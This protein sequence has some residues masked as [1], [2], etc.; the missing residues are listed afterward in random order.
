[1]RQYS[2]HAHAASLTA[3]LAVSVRRSAVWCIES[4]RTVEHDGDSNESL[5][6]WPRLLVMESRKDLSKLSWRKK[7]ED[8]EEESHECRHNEV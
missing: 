6:F 1:M 8:R 2:T 3:P 5:D 7:R 4:L